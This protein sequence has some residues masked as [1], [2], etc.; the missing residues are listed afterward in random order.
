MLLGL[1]III[2]FEIRFASIAYLAFLAFQ[3]ILFQQAIWPHAILVGTPLAMLTHG[4]DKYTVGGRLFSRG[5]LEPI[6]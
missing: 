3:V 1:F 2:G 5:N 6:L 4:Y